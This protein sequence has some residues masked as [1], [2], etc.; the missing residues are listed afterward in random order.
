M[1]DAVTEDGWLLGRKVLTLHETDLYEEARDRA[2]SLVK[3]AGL[4]VAAASSWPMQ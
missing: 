1:A 2:A 3:R 4:E